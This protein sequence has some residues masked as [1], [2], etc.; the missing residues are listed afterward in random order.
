MKGVM[1]D[2]D[3]L[4]CGLNF[5][6]LQAQLDEL[7]IW[8]TTSPEQVAKRINDFNVVLVNKVQLNRAL[9]EQ[10]KSLKLICVMATG[11][12]NVDLEAAAELG[13]EVRNVQAY[14]TAS[15]AQH[16]LMLMLALA[17]RLPLYQQS[18]AAGDWQQAPAFCLM[19]HPVTQLAGKN[20]L[21]VGYGELGQAVGKLA[22]AF[23]MKLL[24]A[25]RPGKSDDHRP[26]LD[27]LLPQADVISFHCPL[28]ESTRG[29]L[30]AHNLQRTKPDLLVVNA[31]RGGIV[32]ELAALDALRSRQIAGLA[33]DVLTEEP[34]R[35]GNPLLDALQES[36]NLIVTP[37]NAW[38]APEA[39]QK[40]VDL[41]AQN[42]Q[43]H[44]AK[45]S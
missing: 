18:L 34:P 45:R 37:H 6:D 9:L 2:A 13:I 5:S 16:T 21:L 28:N 8:P 42:I 10:A 23:G 27:E 11:M 39:R 31:A 36:L 35:N 20:L 19:Q 3:S 40:I 1:L 12:N 24:I 33:V 29:L 38:I 4:G 26:T 41:T 7:V 32:D 44:Q 17:T 30:N 15:V 25:A 14:G 43:Q 22:N